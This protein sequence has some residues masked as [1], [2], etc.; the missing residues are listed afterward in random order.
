MPSL[1]QI[2]LIGAFCLA[3][4]TYEDTEWLEKLGEKRYNVMRKKQTERSY[5]GFY[6]PRATP[7]IFHCAACDLP[8]FHSRDQ[9][10]VGNGWPNFT[11]PLDKK[12]VYYLEDW[13]YGFKCYEVLC[14]GCDSHL[15][16]V[17]HDGPPPKH[18]RFCINSI[19]LVY[20][21]VR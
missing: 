1:C 15:G 10:D 20:S 4:R 11:Y 12:N 21:E 6:L 9:Y 3:Y 5:S 17:F 18:L 13:G 8:L 19:A 16:H 2:A 14:R 7:A